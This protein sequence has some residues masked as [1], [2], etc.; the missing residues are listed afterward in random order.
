MTDRPDTE[1]LHE[2]KDEMLTLLEEAN[3]ILRGTHEEDRAKG[4]W[5]AHIRCALDGEHMF[6]GGS[7]VTM[8]D[9][10]DALDDPEEDEAT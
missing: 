6:I 7:M 8:Q 9:S 3:Q 1:R 10:I 2:I 4:Y 5:Y